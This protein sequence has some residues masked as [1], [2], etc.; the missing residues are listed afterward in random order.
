[1][2]EIDHHP[3]TLPPG[4]LPTEKPSV[5]EWLRCPECTGLVYGKRF[6]RAQHVCPDCGAH[7]RLTARQRLDHLLDPGSETALAGLPGGERTAPEDPLGFVDSRPY[8]ERLGEA[9]AATGMADA[10]LAVRG[11]IDGRPVVAVAMDFRFLGGSLGCAVG[12]L[13]CHAAQTSLRTRTPLLIVAASGGARMQEGAL[14]LMQMATTAQALAELD[15]AGILVVSLVTD[16][17]YGGVAASFATLADVILIEPGARMGFAGPRVIEQ[18][19]GQRLPDGFQTAEF[20]LEHGMVDAVVPRTQLRRTLGALLRVGAAAPS[21]GGSAPDATQG[22]DGIRRDTGTGAG[23]IPEDRRPPPA[24]P[25]V[26]QAGRG[27][28]QG[29][30]S[31][32]WET[33]RLARHTARPSALDYAERLLEDF[34]ELHGDRMGADCPAVVG[35]PGLL[36]GRPVMLV[37]HH[38]GGDDLAERRRRNFGMASPAGFRKAARLM[39]LAAKLGL[40]VVTLVDT[41]GAD[42]GLDAERGGQAAAIAENLR[43]MSRLPVPVVSVVTGEG[44]SGGALALAVADR[45]LI[46]EHGVYSVIS[47]E[48]CA[49]I[50]WKDPAAAPAAADALRLGP[51]DLLDLGVVDA[52]VPEPLGGAHTDPAGA[53]EL[54]RAALCAAVAELRHRAPEQ[55]LSERRDRYRRIGAAPGAADPH[56]DA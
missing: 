42:P 45:V 5:A 52:I 6:A 33:V 40:P 24:T 50:L 56:L 10:A 31:A 20:L 32:A 17:T 43:L 16:P 48:G 19:I 26:P 28:A 41:P 54:L 53:A 18:T 37:G 27:A 11:T 34:H 44:G 46:C 55:L 21:H 51:R 38:K 9:R 35:G 29:I 2:V 14:S 47:P 3:D 23:T 4:A 22:L 15:E 8:R 1:M 36:D 12:R 49:A 30:G 13:V 7:A 39:R 25:T